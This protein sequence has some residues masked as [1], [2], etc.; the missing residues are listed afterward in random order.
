MRLE[1]QSH[2]CL[3][4]KVTHAVGLSSFFGVVSFDSVIDVF[5]SV[6]VTVN[7]INETLVIYIVLFLV[8]ECFSE[9]RA[10]NH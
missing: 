7:H 10:L 6:I 1:D 4:I 3:T 2:E 5:H 9:F 8:I